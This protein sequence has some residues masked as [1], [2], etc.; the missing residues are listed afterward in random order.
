MVFYLFIWFF[1]F[2]LAICELYKCS[3]SNKI[4]FF[5]AVLLLLLFAGLRYGIET[6][7]WAYYR[8]F[9][10]EKQRGIE[11]GFNLLIDLYKT[12]ISQSFDGFIF[13]VALLSISIK[14]FFFKDTASPFWGL[15]IYYSLFYILFEY[16][17]IRQGLA[18]SFLLIASNYAK[19]K[20]GLK[21]FVFVVIASTFHI[22]SVLFMP[23]YFFAT[24]S[25]FIRDVFVLIFLAFSIC[26]FLYPVINLL[27]LTI[28]EIINQPILHS[29]IKRLTSYLSADIEKFISI[30][31][32]R[33]FVFV[34]LFIWLNGKK[35]I[36]N[37][38]FNIY[39]FGYILYILFMGNAILSTRLSASFELFMAPM[40]AV[41]IKERVFTWK[42]VYVSGIISFVLLLLYIT[43]LINGDAIPYQT[44]INL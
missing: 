14:Y 8:I 3:V 5:I 31:F 41:A 19:K 33:R 30:G 20:Q 28:T 17:I 13:I 40:F 22:S 24:R 29:Y 44:F 43:V 15:L 42:S 2:L 9:N 4:T 37:I 25:L 23:V 39:M 1:L 6:D 10:L 35:K 36:S 11:P 27:L 18:A 34:C 26:L 32:M 16:N 21:F 7:Y 12:Y 38:Y